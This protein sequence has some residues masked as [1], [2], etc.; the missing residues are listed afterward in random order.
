LTT[1]QTTLLV[2]QIMGE[3]K[4]SDCTSV[5]R[6]IT[7]TGLSRNT[8]NAYMN[9]L[10]IAKLKFPFDSKVYISNADYTRLRA[11]IAENREEEQ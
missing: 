3:L 9:A 11:F 8:L 5:K 7:E 4:K 6:I 2:E 10:G 1:R